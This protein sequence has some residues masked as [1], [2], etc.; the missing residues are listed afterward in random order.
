[1]PRP[2]FRTAGNVRR[3]PAALWDSAYLRACRGEAAHPAPVWLM[4]QAGRY[5]AEYRAVRAGRNFLDLCYQPKLAA[6]VTLDAQRILG[7]DAAI[8]FADILLIL[9]GL[10]Q[11]LTF[12]AGEGPRLDP[13]LRRP[14]DLDRL[15]DPVQ[16][17]AACGAVAESCR[18]VRAGLPDDVPLIGF[19]GAPYTVAAYAIEGGSSRQFAETRGFMYRHPDAWHRLQGI[20]VA[21]LVP[22]LTAQVDA[23]AQALQLFDSWVGKLPLADY[24]EFVQPHVA[25]LIAA[26]PAGIPITL[27]GTETAHLLPGFAATGADVIG[28]DATTDLRTAWDALGGPARISVQGNLDPAL[29]LAPE[30]R[31]LA[32]AD[33]LLDQVAGRPGW[34]ANLGHGVFQQTDPARVLALVR[35]LHARTTG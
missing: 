25:A 22:Y 17:A 33:R 30:E 14:E 5:M 7:V 3:M 23:G 31:M 24:R 1:M 19:A 6:Q 15:G 20:L 35:H 11:T 12:E 10:G 13:P 27:F 8:I 34:I 18:R 29:L 28:I 26:L 32:A 9:D 16:A 4:R 2:S 21:A